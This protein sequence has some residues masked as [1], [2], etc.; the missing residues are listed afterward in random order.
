M[1]HL[2]ATANQLRARAET[3]TCPNEAMRLFAYARGLTVRAAQ[4]RL[5]MYIQTL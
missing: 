4:M 5:A 3:C 2:I 1:E